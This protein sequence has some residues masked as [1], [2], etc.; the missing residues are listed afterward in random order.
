[1]TPGQDALHASRRS[2]VKM[3]GVVGAGVAT[4][5]PRIAA[6]QVEHEA[7][8]TR[9]HTADI[10]FTVN[11]KTQ[12]LSLDTRTTLLDALRENLELTGTK[13]DHRARRLLWETRSSTPP[14]S[15]YANSPS[16]STKS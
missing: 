13:K 16:R 2:F 6:A 7:A 10:T 14:A 11:G 9:P 4:G 5:L 8:S 3:A 12:Q 15:A 1:L